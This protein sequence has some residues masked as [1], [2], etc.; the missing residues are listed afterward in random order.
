MIYQN[1][2]TDFMTKIRKAC[3]LSK[4][5]SKPSVFVV[6]LQACQDLEPYSTVLCDFRGDQDLR[7]SSVT[8]TDSAS[9][10]CV[11]DSKLL[12]ELSSAQQKPYTLVLAIL[13]ARGCLKGYCTDMPPVLFVIS[14]CRTPVYS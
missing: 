10:G 4:H 7:A 2:S 9:P 13:R 11:C 12:L 14:S 1:P 5:T 6:S 3:S 8:G